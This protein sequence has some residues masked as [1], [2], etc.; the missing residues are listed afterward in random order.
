VINPTLL[1]DP[2]GFTRQAQAAAKEHGW[3]PKFEA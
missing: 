1:R 2:N 3:E